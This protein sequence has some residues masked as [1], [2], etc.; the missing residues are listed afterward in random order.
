[1]S[2]QDVVNWV[3]GTGLSI[4]VLI[5]F[6][7]IIRRRFARYFGS[8]AA[9]AL[10]SLPVLRL[11]MPE[12]TVPF[13]SAL[14]P[15][16]APQSLPTNFDFVATPVPYEAAITQ[17]FPVTGILPAVWLG[18]AVIMLAGQ[19]L[20]Q[21]RYMKQ[22]R[23][24]SQPKQDIMPDIERAVLVSG[25]KNVPEFRIAGDNTGPLVAGLTRP[26][27]VLP[28]DFADTYSA[29][30]RHFALV[31]ECTHIRRAD[32]W[33]AFAAHIFRAFNWPNPLVH[34]AARAFRADQEAACDAA[35]LQAVG[36]CR[37]SAHSYAETLLHAAKHSSTQAT[38]V[39]L[40]LTIHHPLK[41]RLMTLHTNTSKT[42]PLSRL[43]A[44]STMVLALAATAPLTMANSHPGETTIDVDAKSKSKQVIKWTEKDDIGN[45]VSKHYEVVSEDGETNAWEIDTFGNKTEVDTID[46][47]EFNG[48]DHF[49]LGSGKAKVKVL[50]IGEGDG[51][52]LTFDG[53]DK[54]LVIK[55]I[56][57]DGKFTFGEDT[58]FP[59]K[60][61]TEDHKLVIKQLT[62]GE[63]AKVFTFS[64][65]EDIEMDSDGNSF[66]FSDGNHTKSLVTAAESMLSNVKTDDLSS[67]ARR[68]L[69]K[70]QRALKDAK[71]ALEAED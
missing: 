56:V 13:I 45:E 25:L 4:A 15:K 59:G 22:M 2:P 27:I 17:A 14:A 29:D 16:E 32:L 63:N 43:A 26:V 28:K 53:D 52:T 49:E 48:L 7:L 42:G 36:G 35:V 34:Y 20:R 39:P 62:D 18:G 68:K 50:R 10:W 66:F 58:E 21:N 46:I 6:V 64:S 33:A 9:Y 37:N 38:A 41:E 61:M 44:A 8:H 69:E 60:L 1:M 67:S 5:A 54:H 65:D 55:R 71:E 30:Q 51:K 3:V 70:A 57:K 47:K 31:H 40:G 19:A 24:F 23:E 11:F 12:I